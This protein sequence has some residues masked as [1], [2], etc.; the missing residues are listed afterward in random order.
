MRTPDQVRYKI[1]HFTMQMDKNLRDRDQFTPNSQEYER[2]T[3]EIGTQAKVIE[4][5][6]WTLS[7]DVDLQP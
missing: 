6:Y 4:A 3:V 5:L 1:H 7:I 2:L